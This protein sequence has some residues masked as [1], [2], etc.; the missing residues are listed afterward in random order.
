MDKE[1]QAIALLKQ[2]DLTGL[3]FLVRQYQAKAVHT[4]YLIVGDTALAEDIV[5]SAFLRIVQK[6]N[7]FDVQ[8]PFRPWFLRAVVNDAI[9]TAKRQKR[10]ISLDGSSEA[11]INWL[12]DISPKPEEL[13]ET[14][15]LRQVVWDALQQLTPEQRAVIVQRHFLEMSEAEMV[16]KLQ[17]PASTIKWW[18]HTARERLKTLLGDY[19]DVASGENH[20]KR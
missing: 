16:E 18:L 13:T 5:Q 2:G 6:I 15:D 10:T 17:R 12:L 1:Q 7:Q 3:E 8:R 4:A 9:K 14:N 19:H 20:E 11:I